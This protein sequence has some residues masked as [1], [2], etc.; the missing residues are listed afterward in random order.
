[1]KR[2]RFHVDTRGHRTPTGD[3]VCAAR[4]CGYPWP[5]GDERPICCVS[6]M[7]AWDVAHGVEWTEA[8]GRTE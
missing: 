2:E 5:D 7:E 1:M 3:M 4:G 6:A 8:P